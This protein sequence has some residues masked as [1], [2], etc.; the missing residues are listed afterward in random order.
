MFRF[1]GISQVAYFDQMDVI[2][3]VAHPGTTVCFRT[4]VR[5]YYTKAKILALQ[6][7]YQ[8]EQCV[9]KFTATSQHSY[10]I[11]QYGKHRKAEKTVNADFHCL[12]E[13]NGSSLFSWTRL[14]IVYFDSNGAGIICG[15]VHG[16]WNSYVKTTNRDDIF[17]LLQVNQYVLIYLD[18][19]VP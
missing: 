3:L 7:Q 18:F 1:K 14:N 9:T 10:Q 16:T 15:L 12:M 13:Y 4:L 11:A 19:I 6:P 8:I 17:Q 2:W 5:R